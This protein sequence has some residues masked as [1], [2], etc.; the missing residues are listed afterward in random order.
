V[1]TRPMH[2]RVMPT[3]ARGRLQ[4]VDQGAC[5]CGQPYAKA[6]PSRKCGHCCDDVQCRR[7]AARRRARPQPVGR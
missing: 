6:C 1:H 2:A 5:T 7:H 4:G 3:N